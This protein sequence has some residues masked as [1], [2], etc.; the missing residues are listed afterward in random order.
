[1]YPFEFNSLA[2][3]A[4]SHRAHSDWLDQPAALRVALEP[5]YLEECEAKPEGFLGQ[6]IRCRDLVN[7]RVFLLNLSKIAFLSN[8][9]IQEIHRKDPDRSNF[10]YSTQIAFGCVILYRH[11]IDKL[12]SKYALLLHNHVLKTFPLHSPDQERFAIM[13]RNVLRNQL[14]RLLF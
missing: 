10:Y 1:M 7:L 13:H 12:Y 4:Y 2:S 5:E 6:S 8:Q 3:D 9:I 11:Q 14:V